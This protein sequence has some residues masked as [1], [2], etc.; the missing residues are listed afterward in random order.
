MTAEL[1]MA[2]ALLCSP[3]MG[4]ENTPA[5]DQCQTELIKCYSTDKS[6]FKGTDILVQCYLKHAEKK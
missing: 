5:K 3:P 6:S 4:R 2:L 1:L